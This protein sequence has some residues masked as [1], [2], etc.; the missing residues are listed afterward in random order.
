MPP[1][2]CRTIAFAFCFLHGCRETV[3]KTFVSDTIRENLEE[4]LRLRRELKHRKPRPLP[5]NVT[6]F[7]ELE[8]FDRDGQDTVIEL[9]DAMILKKMMEQAIGRHAAR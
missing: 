8:A 6:W 3:G 9:I 4:I 5:K 2:G 1:D 7:R